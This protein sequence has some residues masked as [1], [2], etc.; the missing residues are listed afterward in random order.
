MTWSDYTIGAKR[1]LVGL[2]FW[3]WFDISLHIATHLV[4]VPHA[5]ANVVW[6]VSIPLIVHYMKPP[7]ARLAVIACNV[8][9]WCFLL[10]FIVDYSGALTPIEKAT[11]YFLVSVSQ[12]LAC[13][14]MY[15]TRRSAQE[16]DDGLTEKIVETSINL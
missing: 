1:S 9:Y 6:W 13:T 8:A 15:F 11:F 12:I 16:M 3:Q 10:W 2:W 14:I 5:L 4:T 7:T